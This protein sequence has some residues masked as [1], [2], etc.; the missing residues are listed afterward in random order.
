MRERLEVIEKHEQS[1]KFTKINYPV[2]EPENIFTDN[3]DLTPEIMEK[4]MNQFKLDDCT[5]LMEYK[6]HELLDK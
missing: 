3:K 5:E 1:T 4:F 6:I 2:V